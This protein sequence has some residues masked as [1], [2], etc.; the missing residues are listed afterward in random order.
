MACRMPG[1][2]V[3]DRRWLVSMPFWILGLSFFVFFFNWARGE[4][5]LKRC[6]TPG[7]P[8]SSHIQRGTNFEGRGLFLED[9]QRVGDILWNCCHAIKGDQTRVVWLSTGCQLTTQQ[10][11]IL[12]GGICASYRRRGAR[13]QISFRK[14]LRRCSTSSFS[15]IPNKQ[16]DFPV[17]GYRFPHERWH[18]HESHYNCYH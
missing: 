4:E 10:K 15:P 2:I 16:I 17:V 7:H 14:Q 13:V 8:R 1:W 12:F 3:F 11:S 6:I 9:R 5:K 18:S